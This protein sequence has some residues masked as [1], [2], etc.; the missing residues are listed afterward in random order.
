AHLITGRQAL[1]L[2]CLGRTEIDLQAEG[3]QFVTTENS[4]AVVETSEGKLPPASEQL[5]SEPAIVGRLAKATFGARSSVDWDALIGNYDLIREAIEQV[6]PDFENYNQR[7][8][9][10]GGFYLP[11]PIRERQFKT[12]DGKAHFTV[13]PLPKIDLQPGE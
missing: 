13:H 7:V 2:P 8:R 6:V 4:M 9:Q 12:D 5:L 11:N 3:P 10:P 1:I